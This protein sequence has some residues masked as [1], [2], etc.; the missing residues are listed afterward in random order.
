LSHDEHPRNRHIIHCGWCWTVAIGPRDRLLSL[1]SLA[2]NRI[3][4][5]LF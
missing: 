4:W 1:P 5:K 3:Y 2:V